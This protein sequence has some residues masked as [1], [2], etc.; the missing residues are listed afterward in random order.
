[1]NDVLR[2]FLDDFVI[3]Y[4]DDILIYCQSWEEHLVHV[5]KV[6]MLLEE[7][8]LRLNPKKCE[9]GKQSLVYLG[10][11]VVDGE[12]QFDPI[13]VRVIKEWP[14]PKNVTEVPSFMDACQYVRKFI[15]HFLWP[16][17]SVTVPTGNYS[18]LQ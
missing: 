11:M 10:F 6:F 12:L 5:K 9:Y 8:Q 7:H 13:K 1:M 15:R 16:L 18:V 3:I 2:P 14:R 4:L 17:G